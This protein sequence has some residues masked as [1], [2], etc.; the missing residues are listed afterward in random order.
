MDGEL[1]VS[2]L[3]STHC[4]SAEPISACAAAITS[5]DVHLDTASED[6]L[7]KDALEDDS[8]DLVEQLSPG[9]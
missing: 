6:S 8:L 5:A 7:A 9:T 3:P 2:S 1:T 4:L